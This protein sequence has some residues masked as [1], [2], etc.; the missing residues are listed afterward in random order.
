VLQTDRQTDDIMMPRANHSACVFFE[1]AAFS[2]MFLSETYTSTHL[3]VEDNLSVPHCLHCL[4][5]VWHW[6]VSGAGS[7]CIGVRL[8]RVWTRGKVD[9]Q[10]DGDIV[11]ERRLPTGACSTGCCLWNIVCLLL[12]LKL[13][14]HRQR[15]VVSC[16]LSNIPVSRRISRRPKKKFG[17]AAGSAPA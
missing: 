12:L 6:Q 16:C 15:L 9:R 17:Q 3:D 11:W 7:E 5:W 13:C 14:L 10:S 1:T 8:Q 4:R 2:V